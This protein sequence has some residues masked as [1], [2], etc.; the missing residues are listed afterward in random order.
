MSQRTVFLDASFWIAL[1]DPREPWH[2]IARDCTRDLLARRYLFVF[3][4]FVLAETHAHFCRS[5]RLRTQILDD[6]EHNPIMVNELPS[7]PDLVAT[8]ELLRQH[9]DKSYSFC[10]AFSFVTMRRLRIGQ[11]LAFD[12]H[13]R[14]LGEFE[15]LP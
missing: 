10:D 14:Q 2:R 7:P 6:A 5:P 8:T 4:P 15:V 12:E 11:A 13:F 1:R 3:T 9:G